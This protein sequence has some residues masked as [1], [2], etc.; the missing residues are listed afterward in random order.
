MNVGLAYQVVHDA[1]LF[2]TEP[3]AKE[4]ANPRNHI[5]ARARCVVVYDRV[6][7]KLLKELDTGVIV[8]E[9]TPTPEIMAQFSTDG[10]TPNT[11]ANL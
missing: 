10:G 9:L 7:S 8:R 11:P 2:V 5:Y 3:L 4:W 6:R 1:A